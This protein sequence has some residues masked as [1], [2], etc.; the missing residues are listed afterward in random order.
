V[1]SL[2]PTAW[3][4]WLFFRWHAGAA[5]SVEVLVLLALVALTLRSFW[6]ARSLAGWLM[7]PYLAWVG[8]ASA[9]TVAIWRLNPA[10][11]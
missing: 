2:P 7:L 6:R 4:T 9:L 3:W 1:H 10:V 5:A 8:F 11:L